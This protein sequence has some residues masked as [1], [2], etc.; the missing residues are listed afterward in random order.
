GLDVDLLVVG[1]TAVWVFEVKHWTGLIMCRDGHW[2]R[3]KNYYSSQGALRC[4]EGEIKPFDRQWIRERKEI[5]ETLRRRVRPP[6][7]GERVTGGLV[8]THLN[9]VLDIDESVKCGFGS[10]EFWATHLR[11]VAGRNQE[12]ITLSSKLAVLDGLLDRAESIDC[13]YTQRRC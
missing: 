3:S 12:S 7:L 10:P 1:P 11:E 13:G 4:D 2:W 8:F 6:H 5:Q 9:V